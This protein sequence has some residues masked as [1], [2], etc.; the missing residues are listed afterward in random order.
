MVNKHCLLYQEE[1][2]FGSHGLYNGIKLD[3][4]EGIESY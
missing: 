3:Y 2:V 1:T 4:H